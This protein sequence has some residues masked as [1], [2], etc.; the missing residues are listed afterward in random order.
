MK[1]IDLSVWQTNVD[2]SKLKEQGIEFAIIRCGYGKNSSQKDKEFETHYKG[3]K[4]NGI[5][6]GCY[7]YSY[8]SDI[9]S[10][11]DEANNCLS[12]I[13]GKTFDLPIFYD[14]EEERTRI[15]GKT[16]ITNLAIIFCQTIEKAG[17]KAG[18]YANLNWFTNYI[19]IETLKNKGYKIWL[20]E[21]NKSKESSIKCDIWQYSSSGKIKGIRGNVDLN[22]SYAENVDNSIDNKEQTKKSNEEITEEVIKGNWGNGDIRKQKL[23][24]A[25][26]N[27]DEIQQLVNKKLNSTEEIY[28]VKSGDNLTN[29]AKHY[30]TTIDTIVKLNNI[31]NPNLIY[32]GQKLKIK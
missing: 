16:N 18:V 29:I 3:L 1:G 23:Q 11:V 22:I 10:A 25:G 8:A 5:K 30:G 4:E 2:Y 20:A 17:Y 15:L 21:W 14:L 27:Y 19:D 7:L 9:K 31:K 24:E 6:I 28:I 12:F 26:Y 32:V 13:K